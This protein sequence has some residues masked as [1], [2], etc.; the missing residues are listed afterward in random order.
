MF[1]RHATVRK[2][3]KTHTYW[4]L[5]RSVRRGRKVIQETVAHLGELDAEGRAKASAL[6]KHFLG[7]RAEGPSLF[8]DTRP[9]ATEKA[10]LGQI[11][12]ERS[13]AFGDVWLGLTIW[14]ALGLDEFC[15]AAMPCGREQVPWATMAAIQVI[16]RLCE[17]SSELHIAEDWYRRTALEDLLG[18]DPVH[19]THKRLYEALDK[20]LPHKRALEMH[21]KER[22]GKLFALDFDLLLYD[23]TSTYFEGQA[24]RNPMAKRG[25]SRDHRPDCKQVCIGLVVT[26][27][28]FPL[29]YEVFDGN[30][31]DMTTLEKV[32]REMEGRYGKAK[33]VWVM[34]RGFA[35]RENLEWMQK[36]GRQY[37]VGTPKAELKKWEAELLEKRGWSEI[38]DGLEVKLV[39]GPGGAETFILCRSEDRRKKEEAMHARFTER[40]KEDLQRLARR[41]EKAK[42]PQDRS[43]AE[44]Q[45]GRMLERNSRAAGRFEVSIVEDSK[46]ESGLRLEWTEDKDWIDWAK[47]TDGTYILRTNVATWDPAALWSTYVQLTEAEA[48]FRIQKSDLQIRPVWHQR[49]DRVLAHILVCFLGYAMW[50]TIQGW[51]RNAFL[52]SSPRTVIEEL[53]Q[54]KSV[55]VV[56]P[57]ESGPEMCLRCV[58]RPEKSQKDLLDRMGLRLPQRLKLP[59]AV[60]KCSDNQK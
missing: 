15:E 26:R 6:A 35:S 44:R 12:V 34:D 45:I 36:E 11:R 27:D 38:R 58:V 5:V 30:T 57:L 47:L 28:G 60:P 23:V 21:L 37:L 17:P 40:L 52:G 31:V 10:K 53:A 32:V 16:A 54:I 19:V 7:K 48:A 4:R 42:K 41:L 9:I 14:Q 39:N 33:R 24:M 51:M 25:Y 3:G 2:N 1:L 50:K 55:D 20:I 29:G 49:Q 59:T 43:K 13:R 8:E 46:R 18:V 22:V 56:V